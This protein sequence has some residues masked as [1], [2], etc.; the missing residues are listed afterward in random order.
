MAHL[1]LYRKYRSQTFGDLMGQEHVVRTLQNSIKTG[2]IAHSYLLTGPR[3]TGKTSTARLLAKAVNCVNG[4]S[5]EPCNVCEHCVAISQGSCLD[6][7]EMDAASESTVDDVR[8]KIVAATDYRPATCRYKVFIIDEVH[9]LSA[10]AFDALLK[11]VEEPPEHIIFVLATTEYTKVPA[12]IRS[13]CQKFEF[14]RATMA[15]L[16]G[17]L[18]YVCTQEGVD[19]ERAALLA[20]ARMAD[21]G[22]R[23]AL[24]LLEQAM[25]VSDGKVTLQSVYDQMGLIAD[26]QIDELMLAIKERRTP[27]LLANLDEIYRTGRDPRS[28]LESLL[29]RVSDLTRTLYG[30]EIGSLNDAALEATLKSM[31]SRIGEATLT[32]IRTMASGALKSVRDVTLPRLWLEAELVGLTVETIAQ[33]ASV[34]KPAPPAPVA[35]PSGQAASSAPAKP[36]PVSS[37]PATAVITP[38]QEA[39]K[40][41]AETPLAAEGDPELVSEATK[42]WQVV[43]DMMGEKSPTA[44]QKLEKTRVVKVSGE[45][46]KV[47]FSRQ[48]DLDWVRD[49]A[50]FLPVLEET[51]RGASEP[52]TQKLTLVMD[53]QA[54]APVV[55]NENTAE[56][57][58]TGEKLLKMGIEVFKD[59]LDPRVQ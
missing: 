48:L 9:D 58:A 2:R 19:A 20:L 16:M 43:R 41:P 55:V 45:E 30:V 46:V 21:G 12:T 50:K 5:A 6:V 42:A 44:R 37:A 11:T 7:Y 31:S 51:W 10:K 29:Y 14:H 56:L 39:E 36:A 17:R 27:D 32:R 52:R 13:R 1:A 57:P 4:P 24:T 35:P 15:D 54:K 23:D 53:S 8:D 22:Y 49:K 40:K 38:R 25:L 33:P 34:S 47:G 28:I 3:G 26:E 18:E 59:D